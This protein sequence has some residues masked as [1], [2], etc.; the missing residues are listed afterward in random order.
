MSG[1]ADIP[2]TPPAHIWALKA[3]RDQILGG[4]P[5]P[6][7]PS[8]LQNE[9]ETVCSYFDI[10]HFSQSPSVE[11][12]PPSP[13][14]GAGI[15][16][17]PGS[18]SRRKSVTFNRKSESTESTN[19]ASKASKEA[20][21]PR[22]TSI[23]N[24]GF[25][26]KYPSP[27]TPRTRQS[28]SEVPVQHKDQVQHDDGDTDLIPISRSVLETVSAHVEMVLENNNRLQ[29]IISSGIL[30]VKPNSKYSVHPDLAAMKE[31]LEREKEV[32]KG[33]FRDFEKREMDMK[34]RETEVNSQYLALRQQMEEQYALQSSTAKTV[35]DYHHTIQQLNQTIKQQRET[36]ETDLNQVQVRVDKYEEKMHSL[37]DELDEARDVL[38]GN[39]GE[40]EQRDYLIAETQ[41]KL[42]RTQRH[43][44][45]LRMETLESRV[46]PAKENGLEN[47][48]RVN[49]GRFGSRRTASVAYAPTATDGKTFE[50]LF[51][52]HKAEL[53]ISLKSPGNGLGE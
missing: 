15:L 32:L 34:K 37:Q 38:R 2:D 49:H 16:K 24:R 43:L 50:A 51:S 52:Q 3:L 31:E 8:N 19:T 26:G 21:K 30:T 35:E 9:V 53:L 4:R 29:Q 46:G 12:S 42:K 20:P 41:E 25:P 28:T 22:H 47:V 6:F 18:I 23:L 14:K 36:F 44:S 40:L 5:T 39:Q 45:Q 27:Y 17:T 1:Y 10:T 48:S 33:F 13:S 7:R 11:S